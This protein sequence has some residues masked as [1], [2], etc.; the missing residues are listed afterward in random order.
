[1][2][3]LNE[4]FSRRY[5]YAFQ[6][7]NKTAVFIDSDVCKDHENGPMH[8]ENP[9][10][11]TAVDSLLNAASVSSFIER[12]PVTDATAEQLERVHNK[13]YVSAIEKTD[14]G[15]P[16]QLDQ[17]TG[18][19]GGS[20]RA[21][22]RSA[23]AAVCAC[24][25]VM[26]EG[27]GSAF[28]FCRPPGHHA[29]RDRA[30]GFCLFNNIAVAAEFAIAECGAE[31]VMIV[32]WDVHHGNGTQNS[33]Y[34]RGDV[35]YFS[36]HQHPAFPGT[37]NAEETGSGEGSETTLNIPLPAGRT[38][39]VY[40]RIFQN[41]LARAARSY[42]P[43]LILVSAGFDAHKA[44]PLGGMELSSECFGL[45]ATEIKKLAGEL[46]GGKAVFVLEGGYDLWSLQTSVAEV[47]WTLGGKKAD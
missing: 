27:G 25:A 15:P 14:G 11:I 20:W 4:D 6:V 22:I 17:D 39:E 46:C 33:F 41:E 44:D 43:D 23:G 7:M 3:R 42:Q 19:G 2:A 40:I 28:A 26:K 34:G 16:L 18:A 9:D 10:R 1:M 30:M 37:G 13:D 12:M 45:L 38:D 35:F 32:D 31:R 24:G 36:V 5:R 21:A 8:P 29:E 47:L